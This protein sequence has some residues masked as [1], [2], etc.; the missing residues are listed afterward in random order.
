[1]IKLSNKEQIV[2]ALVLVNDTLGEV[3]KI[4]GISEQA[5]KFHLTNIYKKGHF[6]S[7]NDILIKLGKK[8]SKRAEQV[9]NL[10]YAEEKRCKLPKQLIWGNQ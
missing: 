7:K 5:V 9:L 8:V 10:D 3:A 1:M 2:C 4:M 6:V